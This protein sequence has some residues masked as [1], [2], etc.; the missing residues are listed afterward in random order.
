M[1]DSAE[2]SS[3]EGEAGTLKGEVAQPVLTNDGPQHPGH[4][5]KHQTKT[6]V[7]GMHGFGA[8]GELA[9]N[10]V[11]G[12]SLWHIFSTLFSLLRFLILKRNFWRRIFRPS[13]DA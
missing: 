3:E 5:H 11:D 13:L 2:A 7:A 9:K 10:K 6:P 8:L 1:P 4:E 12:M